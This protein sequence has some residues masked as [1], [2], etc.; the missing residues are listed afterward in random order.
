VIAWC[1]YANSMGYRYEQHD[2]GGNLYIEIFGAQL[3][4]DL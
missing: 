1:S 4:T 3:V 2:I